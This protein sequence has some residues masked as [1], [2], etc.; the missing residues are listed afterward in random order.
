M[1]SSSTTRC[2]YTLSEVLLVLGIIA[3]VAALAQ[4]ALRS[5]LGDSRL[6]SAARQL[7]AE[8]AKTRLRAMQSGTAQRFRYQVDCNRFE[9]APANCDAEN[10][11]SLNGEMTEPLAALDGQESAAQTR[12]SRSIVQELPDGVNF[13]PVVEHRTAYVD[14]EGWSDPIVFYPNGRAA[15]ATIRL[16]GERDT[17]V[18]VSLRGLTGV[19]TAGKPRREKALQ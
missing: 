17:L 6:R 13:E 2:G 3:G 5:S 7:R 14:E 16:R 15:D 18:D 4:P 1:K 12:G 8:L 11:R 9:T 19:A 10:D